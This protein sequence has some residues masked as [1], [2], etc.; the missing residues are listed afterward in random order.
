MFL[1]S[2]LKVKYVT[3]S[4]LVCLV[5][6]NKTS[7]LTSVSALVSPTS[8]SVSC[9]NSDFQKS[10]SATRSPIFLLDVAC[11]L[12]VNWSFSCT[13]LYVSARSLSDVDRCVF[14][15]A[16]WSVV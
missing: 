11:C 16:K 5:K 2:I 14:E 3:N 12:F 4:F 9:L 13:N 7:K 8:K 6:E 1:G 15:V 10:I